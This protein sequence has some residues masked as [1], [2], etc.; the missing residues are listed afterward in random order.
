[1]SGYP[2]TFETRDVGPVEQSPV[3]LEGPNPIMT[4]SSERLAPERWCG[5][6][7]RLRENPF[8]RKQRTTGVLTPFRSKI[9]GLPLFS[10]HSSLYHSPTNRNSSPPGRK[11][12]RRQCLGQR[13]LWTH[14]QKGNR[15]L[16][17]KSG[18]LSLGSLFPKGDPVS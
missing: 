4:I 3:S 11:V 1:M 18:L 8:V 5:D 12:R 15:G 13:A 17:S 9:L 6:R 7:V 10:F 16:G 14:P 2:P